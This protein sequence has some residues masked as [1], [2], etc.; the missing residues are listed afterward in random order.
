MKKNILTTILIGFLAT[1]AMACGAPGAD[2]PGFSEELGDDEGIIGDEQNV[3]EQDEEAENDDVV[4][5]EEEP[6]LEGPFCGDGFVDDGEECDDGNREDNDGCSSVC[7]VEEFAGEAEGEILID[8]VIDDLN[9]NEAPLEADCTGAIAL[10]VADGAL[11]GE[12][13]CALP[14][15]FLDYTIDAEVDEDGAVEGDI[16]IVLNNRPNVLRIS[17]TLESAVLSLEFDGVTILVGSIRGVW[18]GTI[19]ADFD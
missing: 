18:D 9:S 15:N 12:G 13:R 6:G 5:E 1:L 14:A 19:V 11:A 2:S 8:L 3:D 10:S 17:G 4:D 16:T 7:E